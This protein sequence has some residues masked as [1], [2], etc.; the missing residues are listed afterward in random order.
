MTGKPT[1]QARHIVDVLG[2]RLRA[3]EI[4]GYPLT[5]IDSWLR[6]DWVHGK[7]HAHILLR[8]WA[9]GVKMNHLDFVAHL[10][11]LAPAAERQ[12]ERLAG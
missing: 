4:T 1:T 6:T 11:G 3:H 5:V 7:Y 2:G 9:A 8:A 12:P 10:F